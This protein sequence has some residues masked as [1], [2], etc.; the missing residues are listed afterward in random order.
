MKRARDPSSWDASISRSKFPSLWGVLREAS[1][2]QGYFVDPGGH[3]QGN[4]AQVTQQVTQMRHM[5]LAMAPAPRVVCESGFN[6]G[7]SA[8][9]WLEATSAHLHT[10]DLGAEP[11]SESSQAFIHRLYPG[12]VT[13]HKGDSRLTMKAHAKAVREGLASECDLAFID[14][15]HLRLGPL[16]DLQYTFLFSRDGALVIADDCTNRFQHVRHAWHFM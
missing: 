10:F 4:S 11:Y 9:V 8:V 3:S 16:L 5:L 13:Y 15:N 7:H 14:G 1:A 6:A 2:I 12:R